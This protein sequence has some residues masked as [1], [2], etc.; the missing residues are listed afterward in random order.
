LW[1]LQMDPFLL[2][3]FVSVCIHTRTHTHTHLDKCCVWFYFIDRNNEW[4]CRTAY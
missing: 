1:F 4:K 3:A 2:V